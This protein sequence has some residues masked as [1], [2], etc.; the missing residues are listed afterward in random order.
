MGN[1]VDE[2]RAKVEDF[3]D[4]VKALSRDDDRMP[5]HQRLNRKAWEKR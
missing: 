1:R 4:E 3:H 5:F 2:V